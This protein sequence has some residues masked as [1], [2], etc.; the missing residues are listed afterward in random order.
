[1]VLGPSDTLAGKIVRVQLAATTGEEK[2]DCN[3]YLAVFR[4]ANCEKTM[5]RAVHATQLKPS[6]LSDF[7]KWLFSWFL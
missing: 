5:F 2:N 7:V 3:M 4:S 1:M 6:V